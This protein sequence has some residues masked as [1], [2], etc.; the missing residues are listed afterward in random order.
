MRPPP[1]TDGRA[2]SPPF[3]RTAR[4]TADRRRRG[5]REEPFSS[6]RR[7][8]HARP[9]CRHH[10]VLFPSGRARRR[11]AAPIVP[12]LSP[13][14][15]RGAVFRRACPPATVAT[16]PTSSHARRTI[17]R[18]RAPDPPTL[19]SAHGCGSQASLPPTPSRAGPSPREAAR[20][21]AH[22]L[23]DRQASAFYARLACST[24]TMHRLHTHICAR[25]CSCPARSQELENCVRRQRNHFTNTHRECTWKEGG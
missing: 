12:G 19:A 3:P 2:D 20:T 8:R 14:S 18:L 16:S 10:H 24:R 5:R 22:I 15:S 7:H 13:P 23:D 17:H 21:H 4:P 11:D 9:P 25:A 6:G 1:P